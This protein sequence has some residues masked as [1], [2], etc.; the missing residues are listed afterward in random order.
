MLIK[1]KVKFVLHITRLKQHSVVLLQG[2]IVLIKV[3]FTLAFLF[4]GRPPEV[5][6]ILCGAV[7]KASIEAKSN[8]ALIIMLMLAQRFSV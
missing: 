8:L 4:S 3:S 5:F 6:L 2:H 7:T 1:V